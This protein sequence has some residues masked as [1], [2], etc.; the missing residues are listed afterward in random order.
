MVA[1]GLA[2]C[3]SPSSQVGATR[4]D[5]PAQALNEKVA[6]IAQSLLNDCMSTE[7]ESL[8]R[9]SPCKTGDITLAQLANN[10]K[11]NS[12]DRELFIQASDRLDAYSKQ[13]TQTYQ[14]S[15]L[16]SAQRVA[17]ARTWAQF[18]TTQ[19]RLALLNQKITWGEYLRQ[20]MS[21]EAEMLRRAQ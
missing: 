2:A 12:R 13:I 8:R 5:N 6:A 11:I 1:A 21:I 4:E 19:N 9:L 3:S 7:F 17:Q 16:T 18:E 14:Q 15:D 20:R 10:S